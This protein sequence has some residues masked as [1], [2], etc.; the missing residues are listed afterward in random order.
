MWENVKVSLFDGFFKKLFRRH[1]PSP[2]NNLFVNR[3]QRL[4][5][6]VV[7]FASWTTEVPWIKP[8]NN[9]VYAGF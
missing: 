7:I 2:P 6:S 9:N 4:D 3:R 1:S 8:L 5:S